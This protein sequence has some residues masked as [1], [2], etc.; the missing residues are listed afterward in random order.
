MRKVETEQHL[1]PWDDF[2]E[3]DLAIEV[4]G[5]ARGGAEWRFVTSRVRGEV[6]YRRG[7]GC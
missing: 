7:V 5:C 6:R 3:E 1:C 4:V 2:K